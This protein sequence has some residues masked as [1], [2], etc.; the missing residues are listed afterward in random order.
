[1]K[2]WYPEKWAVTLEELVKRVLTALEKEPSL[3]AENFIQCNPSLF[4]TPNRLKS[5]IY[6]VD[7]LIKNKGLPKPERFPDRADMILKVFEMGHSMNRCYQHKG[8]LYVRF[9]TEN[10]NAIM[11]KPEQEPFKRYLVKAHNGL[12]KKTMETST[13]RRVVLNIR[14]LPY[15]DVKLTN[16]VAEKDGRFFYDLSD[17]TGRVVQITA[18]KGWSIGIPKEPLFLLGDTALPAFEPI[19]VSDPITSFNKLW[20]YLP[21]DVKYSL[22]HMVEFVFAF[23]PTGPQPIPSISGETGSAKTTYVKTIKRFIDPGI[24]DAVELPENTTKLA[25]ILSTS[26][27]IMFDNVS[28]INR[29]QSDMLCQAST[30]GHAPSR[31]LYTDTDTIDRDL[32]AV[33]TLN[34]LT[35]TVTEPD[36]MRRVLLFLFPLIP[37]EK[38]MTLQK[39]NNA[40]DSIGPEVLG[41]VF[42]IVSKAMAL[43][44]KYEDLKEKSTMADFEMWACAITE[45][46]GRDPNEFLK[47]YRENQQLQKGEV[48]A[49]DILGTVLVKFVQLSMAL[50][51]S[52]TFKIDKLTL[53]ARLTTDAEVINRNL[54]RGKYWPSSIKG[55]AKRLDKLRATLREIGLEFTESREK[56]HGVQEQVITFTAK[57][58]FV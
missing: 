27:L 12:F 37:P 41:A 16:R 44:P 5:H 18:G 58:V 20:L 13:Y 30:G 10:G 36:L 40:I 48:L 49:A 11:C 19:Q 8:E 45:A 53:L 15:T 24:S 3:T 39:L 4:K 6:L 14:R 46:L 51:K 33:V 34:G 31:K 29:S 21:Q 25:H 7:S 50:E 35:I 26:R 28:Y 55:L 42:D 52:Q 32:G 43:V 57:N 1:M 2:W 38:K 22:L 54:T 23:I 9:A 47:L 17:G 56:V